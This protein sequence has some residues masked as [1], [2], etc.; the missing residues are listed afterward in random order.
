[1]EI[2]AWKLDNRSPNWLLPALAKWSSNLSTICH[3][4]FHQSMNFTCLVIYST[5][6][7]CPQLSVSNHHNVQT[8]KEIKFIFITSNYCIQNWKSKEYATMMIRAYL[9]VLIIFCLDMYDK[10]L[11]Y[12]TLFLYIW[13]WI[14]AHISFAILCT[15]NSLSK[16]MLGTFYQYFLNRVL[17]ENLIFFKMYIVILLSMLFKLISQKMIIGVAKKVV[18]S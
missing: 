3:Q 18:S 17:F 12:F 2:E 10:T 7:L 11:T 6:S 15:I 1:M 9:I 5:P 13:R 8:K 16:C 14:I 4:I